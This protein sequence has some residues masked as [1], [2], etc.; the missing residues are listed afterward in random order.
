MAHTLA[1]LRIADA[2]TDVGARLSTGLGGLTP[3]QAG[4]AP[5][6]RRTKFHELIAS[7]TPSTSLAWSH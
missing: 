2:V 3:G 6:G 4:F 7:F 1:C 5:A